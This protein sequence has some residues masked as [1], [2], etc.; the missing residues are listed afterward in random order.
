MRKIRVLLI[1]D[2]DLFRRSL[3]K[4]LKKTG[5][6]VGSADNAENGLRELR[7]TEWDVVLLDIRLPDRDGLDVLRAIKRF[8][9]SIE[10]IMLTAHGAVD[11]AVSSLKSGAYHYLVK[12]AELAEIDAAIQ[13]AYEKRGLAIENRMLRDKLR[14][15]Q[16]G[17]TLV[18]TSPKMLELLSMV[19]RVAASDQTVLIQGESGTGKELIARRIHRLSPRKEHP[20]VLLDCASLSKNLLESELFGHEK[21]AFTGASGVKQG[22]V[23]A[24]DKGTL[25]ADEIGALEPEIQASFL[26]LMETN[27]YRRVGGTAIRKADLRIVAATNVD[28]RSATREGKFREDLYFRLNVIVLFVPPLRQRKEDIGPLADHF[29]SRAHFGGAPRRLSPA[30]ISELM[31]HNWPG[32]VRELKNTLERAALLC[33]SDTIEV[34]DLK[35]LPSP[36]DHTLKSLLADEDLMPLDQIQ[37]RYIHMVLEKVKGNQ[38]QAARILGVD[39]KTIYRWL[40]KDEA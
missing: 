6:A 12:P 24:A 33:D 30:A 7:A 38:L 29:L 18:G 16:N 25:F 40:K 14:L 11:S 3:V 34:W 17:D 15:D 13:K 23:E 27:E 39:P 20:F 21:G 36:L 19:D 5:F 4:E 32:N 37:A 10:V 22:L 35:M 31:K 8:D 2:D 9:P 1:D 26:R 28:L